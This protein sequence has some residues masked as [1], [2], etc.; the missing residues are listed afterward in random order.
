MFAVLLKILQIGRNIEAP[1]N[2]NGRWEVENQFVNELRSAC[3]PVYFQTKDPEIFIE[4]SGI[5]LVAFLN[6]STGISMKGKLENNKM[7]FSEILPVGKEY[8]KMCGDKTLADLQLTFTLNNGKAEQLAGI[9]K[10][11]SCLQSGEI[12]FHA[13]RK[14]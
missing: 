5:H 12:N 6:N 7:I 14:D 11:P 10:S 1:A 13:V 2:V 9:W 8:E 4:Q 3:T